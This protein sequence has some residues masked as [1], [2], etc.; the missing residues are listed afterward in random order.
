MVLDREVTN[1]VP[2]GEVQSM[3]RSITIIT[4]LVLMSAVFA[5]A[6]SA[7]QYPSVAN[8]TAFSAGANFM[9][10]PGYLR[11]LVHQRTG[12]WLTITEAA[13]AVQ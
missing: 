1:G 2:P 11:Y 3:W 9:S 5:P 10:L 6:V 13:R 8:V 12:Q 4:A 7:Q